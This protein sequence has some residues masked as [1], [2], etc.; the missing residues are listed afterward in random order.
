MSNLLDFEEEYK[1]F[2]FPKRSRKY[3]P[4]ARSEEDN[5]EML[6]QEFTKENTEDF[7]DSPFADRVVENE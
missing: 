3:L 6:S 2:K 4:M 1:P 5:F 7:A